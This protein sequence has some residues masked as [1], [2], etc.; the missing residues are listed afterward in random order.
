[1]VRKSRSDKKDTTCKR[2]G[3]VCVNPN[4][5]REHLRRKNLCKPKTNTPIQAPVQEVNQE[6]IQASES[7]SV[8]MS[9]K[10]KPHVVIPTP[11]PELEPEKEALVLESE[12]RHG[13]EDCK[14]VG[15]N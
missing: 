9:N 13:E 12:L 5:L 1:M 10:E 11:I 14:N 7:S 15:K 3:K 4:K 2:C 8:N 6:A